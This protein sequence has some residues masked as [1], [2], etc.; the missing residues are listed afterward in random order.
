MKR[1]LSGAQYVGARLALTGG[2]IL[3]MAQ[4]A[5]AQ[6]EIGGNE[7]EPIVPSG[8]TLPEM[9][10]EIISI[11][12]A[13]VGVLAVIYLIYGGIQYVTAGGEAEKATKGRTTITNAIIGIVLVAASYA[14]FTY[15]T[16]DSGVI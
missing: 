10:N 6:F 15:V 8:N 12:L 1:V 11:V 14:I 3:A 7:I 13:V 9:V 2:A 4:G 16:R 5:L